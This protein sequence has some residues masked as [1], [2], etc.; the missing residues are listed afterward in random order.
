MRMLF[1]YAAE[2][3]FKN[4]IEAIAGRKVIGFV[5]GSDTKADPPSACELRR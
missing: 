3:E 2:D 1:Q 4:A 5:S